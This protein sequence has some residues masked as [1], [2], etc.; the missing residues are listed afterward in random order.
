LPKESPARPRAIVYCIVPEDLADVLHEPLRRHFRDELGIEVVVEQRWR[1]RRRPK[2]RRAGDAATEEDRRRIRAAAGRRVADRR[3]A[4]V[5]VELPASLPRRARAFADRLLLVERLEPSTQQLEDIDTAR[6][7][8]RIQSGEREQFADL[9]M[10][11]FDRVYSYLLVIL[12]SQHE[13]EDAAQHVFTAVLENLDRYE[14]RAQPFRAWLFRIARNWAI[15][16][17]EKSNRVELTDPARGADL[18]EAAVGSGEEYPAVAEWM[19]DR[20]LVM[21]VERLPLAQ[22]QVLVLRFM[23]DLSTAE[24]AGILD[25]SPDDVRALQSRALRYL[26]QRLTAL[27]RAPEGRAP[28]QASG[29]RRDQA[30]VLRSRRFALLRS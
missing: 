13:A 2:D 3:A 10:R 24:I 1:D 22:R 5:S 29:R 16:E 6:L 19:S 28:R 26:R 4:V 18:L 27:G 7:V 12:R 20:D 9:Y 17:L 11:F 15:R 14:R 25:R 30:V 21:F 23:L 8:A